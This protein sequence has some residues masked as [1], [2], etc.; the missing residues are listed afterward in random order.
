M[1]NLL[2]D[3]SGHLLPFR[4][5]CELTSAL[6]NDFQVAAKTIVARQEQPAPGA[7]INFVDSVEY[8]RQGEAAV[9]IWTYSAGLD[10]FDRELGQIFET[11]WIAPFWHARRIIALKSWIDNVGALMGSSSSLRAGAAK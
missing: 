7:E 2:A 4:M 9:A 8:T 3:L 10:L 6:I 11:L 1:G 5:K